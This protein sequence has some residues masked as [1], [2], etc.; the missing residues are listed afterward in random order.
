MIR[1][2][3]YETVLNCGLFF[4]RTS[5]CVMADKATLRHI[6]LLMHGSRVHEMYP[7]LFC[8]FW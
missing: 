6:L 7:K 5:A 8:W 2:K 3:N 1:A 4:P